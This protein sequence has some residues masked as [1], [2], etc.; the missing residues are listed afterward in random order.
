VTTGNGVNVSPIPWT[1]LSTRL[2]ASYGQPSLGTA[3]GQFVA[4]SRRSTDEAIEQ[5]VF[6]AGGSGVSGVS[7]TVPFSGWQ[8]VADPVLLAAGGGGLQLIL[9]GQHSGTDND[10]FNGTSVVPRNPDGSFGSPTQLTAKSGYEPLG[11]VLAADGTTPLWTSA[12]IGYQML[13]FSGTTEH[14]LTADSPG[15]PIAPTLGRDAA[16]RVWLAW[17]TGVEG[18]SSQSSIG[19]YMMQLDPQTGV[20]LSQPVHAPGSDQGTTFG[21]RI[22]MPCAQTCRLV[23]ASSSGQDEIVSWAPGEG[24][25][26]PVQSGLIAGHPNA[27]GDVVGAYTADG[28]LWVAF[29]GSEAQTYFA[30]LG[31]ARGA[32]GNLVQ[33]PRL[34]ALVP[35]GFDEPAGGAATTIGDSLVIASVWNDG[36]M[37]NST[38]VWATVVNPG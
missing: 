10:P 17:Y 19:L 37:S 20:P 12:W 8:S 16:G 2:D 28:R 38:S 5:A 6:S 9:S 21:I 22:A 13:V 23:Y 35:H 3:G 1:Q 34:R 30:K 32:G 29:S 14:D 4:V 24:A 33:L 26:T 27:L 25:P 15:A 7:Q 36:L 11:A 18:V 31:D